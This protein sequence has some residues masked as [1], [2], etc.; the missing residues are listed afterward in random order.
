MRVKLVCFAV[1]L[2]AFTLLS[3]A[4]L[5][6]DSVTEYIYRSG[7]NT[8]TWQLP[9]HPVLTPVDVSLGSSFTIENLSFI[10]NGVPMVG[11]MDFFN[12][13]SSG[14]FDLYLNNFDF[15][16]NN[17]GPQL[18]FGSE[19]SPTLRS[20]LF[21]LL[22]YGNTDTPQNLG[23]LEAKAVTELVPEPS[24]FALLAAGLVMGLAILLLRKN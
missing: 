19:G 6:A 24:T 8:F 12:S 22:D 14:G 3:A 18:Y 21:F 2:L 9:T 10:E 15:L 1:L 11:T 7:D 13:S 23:I 4:P 5:R 16:V 17:V 20:G